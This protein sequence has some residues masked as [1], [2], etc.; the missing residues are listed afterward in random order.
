MSIAKLLVIGLDSADKDLIL[1]WAA[2]GSLPHFSRLLESGAYGEIHAA[3]GETAGS[4]WPSINTGR[5]QAVHGYYHDWQLKTGSYE[6]ARIRPSDF[7]AAPFW[8]T[9]S[10]AGKR[11]AIIDVPKATISS[12]LNGVQILDWGNHDPGYEQ[13]RSFPESFAQTIESRFGRDPVG[14]CDKIC[15]QNPGAVG[16][17]ALRDA[18]VKRIGI[19]AA[20]IQ[21][22]LDQGPW[23]LAVG[24]FADLHCA[25][26]QFWHVHDRH[27]PRF[28]PDLA[29]EIGNPL[30]DVYI[31][32]DQGIGDLLAKMHPGTRLL[33]FSD[34]GMG[35][36]YSGTFLLRDI[37]RRL[38]T[39]AHNGGR[40]A[41]ET[42]RWLWRNFPDRRD[43]AGAHLI[44]PISKDIDLEVK[45]RDYFVVRSTDDGG[46]IRI[47][48]HGREPAGHIKPGREY[49][50]LC[51]AISQ[52]LATIVNL[53]TGQ[54]LVRADP[55]NTSL[56][57]RP[58]P[59]RPT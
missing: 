20:I 16:L 32:L 56:V 41:V 30:K 51:E 46:A 2:D 12:D 59:A 58:V 1:H 10:L 3:P 23:D 5:S 28:D 15:R 53:E 37:V 14:S 52:E 50:E 54:P 9:L 11:I 19:K 33:V 49:D 6:Y 35:P 21:Y 18:L 55:E 4:I 43:S 34:L 36:N 31:A 45:G 57:R 48:L 13:T 39:D 29:R 7:K 26:H 24:A 40:T 38:H 8:E 42:L 25:G 47:N 44:S 22:V 17:K 27:H